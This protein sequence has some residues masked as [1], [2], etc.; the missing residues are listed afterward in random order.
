MTQGMNSSNLLFAQD[1]EEILGAAMEV[2]N[3]MGHGLL[4]K[5]Y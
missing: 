1:T 5:P 3:V 4:E 2:L